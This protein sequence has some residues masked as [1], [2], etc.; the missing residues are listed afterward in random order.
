MQGRT[1]CHHMDFAI[2]KPLKYVNAQRAIEAA[3]PC[4]AQLAPLV[5]AVM[6]ATRQSRVLHRAQ[7]RPWKPLDSTTSPRDQQQ[8][9]SAVQRMEQFRG[10][11]TAFAHSMLLTWQDTQGICSR[12]CASV[13]KK[14]MLKTGHCRPR[15]CNPTVG[16]SQKA[17][18]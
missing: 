8:C 9:I 13:H 10:S 3:V 6:C 12:S 5:Q 15:A 14:H 11:S 18:L 17:Q 2:H 1:P 7:R 16:V 4:V